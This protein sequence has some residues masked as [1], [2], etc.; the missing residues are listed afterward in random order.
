MCVCDGGGGVEA[1]ESAQ[2][3]SECFETWMLFS[4]G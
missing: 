4:R 2:S 3:Y 1:E